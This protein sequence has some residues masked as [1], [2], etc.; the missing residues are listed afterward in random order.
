MDS[1]SLRGIRTIYFDFDGTLHDTIRVYAPA[2]RKAYAF[3]VE[4]GK[5]EERVWKDEEI[6]QWLGYTSI[7]MWKN[8]MGDLDEETRNDAS[9][10]IGREMRRQVLDGK[11]KLYDHTEEVLDT[12]QKRGYVLVYLS[13]AGTAY[14]D[15]AREQYGLDRY[16]QDMVCAGD[17]GFLPKEEIL[18]KI[19]KDYPMDQV[20]VGDRHHDIV[21]GQVNGMPSIFCRYGYGKEEEG[22]GATFEIDSIEELLDILK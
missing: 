8:F 21:S 16:F 15:V 5:A 10:I 14:R 22:A 19:M 3:L 4:K 17:H 13:N 1:R 20:I 2:F 9:R 12:L 11:G 7:E 18:A 6:G